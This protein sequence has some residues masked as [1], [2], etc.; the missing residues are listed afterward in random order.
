MSSMVRF[1]VALG[2]CGAFGLVGWRALRNNGVPAPDVSRLAAYDRYGF[3]EVGERLGL[4]FD[5]DPGHPTFFYP[6][7]MGAGLAVADFNNDGRLDVLLRGCRPG[8]GHPHFKPGPTSQL[9]L[10]QP[11]GRFEN[12]SAKSGLDDDGYAMGVAVGDVNND[13]A[14][15]VYLCNLGKDKLYLGNG[16]GTFIDVT[17][18]AGIKNV[19]FASSAC[20]VDFDRDGRLDL[21]VANYIDHRVH[22]DCQSIGRREYCQPKNFR[23]LTHALYRNV[24]PPNAGPRS[25]R[26]DDVSE[27]SGVGG[28]RA[29][30]LGVLLCDA[31]DD[32]WPD[33]YVANDDEPNFLWMNRKDGTFVESAASQGV[34]MNGAGQPQ[35]SMGL[36]E[37]D[38]DGDGR[39]DILVT[40]FR[41]E[42]TTVYSRGAYGYRDR[43]GALGVTMLTRP[44][45]GFGL[46]VFD[47]DGD[48]IEEIIQVNGRV[49]QLES[50][51]GVAP[52]MDRG[53]ADELIRFWNA[54]SEPS[55]L[56]QRTGG[57]FEDASDQAGDFG[58]WVGVGRGLAVGDVNGDGHPDLVALELAGRA[59]L[60]LNAAERRCRWISVGAVDPSKGGRDALGALVTIVAQEMKVSKRI[61]TCGSYQSANEPRTYFGLGS[62]SKVDRVEIV[63]PDGDVAPETFSAPELDR[64]YT[65]Q[66]N[67]GTKRR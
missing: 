3:E 42:Y 14:P 49:T 59:R 22:I 10:Q 29:R 56:F 61:R 50:E 44:F 24:T 51:P 38:A 36:S 18:S 11:D 32:G 9:Y 15:D 46:A 57:R 30:G 21:Y 27:Q 60:F 16:D 26:F 5:H 37:A 40:N 4:D 12:A 62:L 17:S 52:P 41:A 67:Q 35:G 13:G 63:W 53:S 39:L 58:R 45:T 33:V 64:A 66:R 20:F 1:V 23:G 43:S 7:I 34:A 31:N 65:F 19:G 2:A 54:Y 55:R 8:K 48:G 6:E 28:K 47:V 25:V